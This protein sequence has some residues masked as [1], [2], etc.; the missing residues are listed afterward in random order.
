MTRQTRLV[1]RMIR[2]LQ[3]QDG[4]IQLHVGDII[5][6]VLGVDH[7]WYL[8]L[9]FDAHGPN[10]PMFRRVRVPVN[11]KPMGPKE[12]GAEYGTVEGVRTSV[13]GKSG[14][15]PGSKRDPLPPDIFRER[16]E[17]I[18]QRL[19]LTIKADEVSPRDVYEDQEW[20]EW[21]NCSSSSSF[22]RRLGAHD[23][24]F[25]DFLRSLPRPKPLSQ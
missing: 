15:P 22:Y 10:G 25:P 23:I 4:T 7:P 9:L 6:D 5:E 2:N 17:G 11:S 14:R 13:R 19:R 8:L 1:H 18:V 12:N 24:N 20:R 21:Q 16:L 3:S